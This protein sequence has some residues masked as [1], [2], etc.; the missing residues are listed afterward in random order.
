MKQQ[1]N[2]KKWLLLLVLL[3]FIVPKTVLAVTSTDSADST[4][5]EQE[6]ENST[7]DAIKKVIQEK[8]TELGTAGAN[9]RSQR[10]FLAKVIRVSQETLT[11]QNYAG[12]RIIPLEGVLIQKA[13][14]EAKVEDIA[15]DSWVSIKGDMVDDNLKMKQVTIYDK[16]F[17]PKDKI[18][19]IGSISSLGN[20]ELKFKARSGE[21]ELNFSFTKD[22][23][24]QDM[25]GE[26]AALADFYEELQCIIVAFADKNGNYVIS[27][28]RALSSF[29]E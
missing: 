3:A 17:S 22:T 11:V 23:A 26:E 2:L 14:K 28:I 24:F 8:K 7:I 20:S 9:V 15:V 19:T 4:A 5:Q 12:S 27:T 13:A 6:D 29:D 16:D 10:A 18:I 25:Q 1:N 21:D